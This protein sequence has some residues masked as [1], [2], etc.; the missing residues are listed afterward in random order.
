M[1]SRFLKAKKRH[2]AV[3]RVNQSKDGDV[4][5]YMYSVGVCICIVLVNIYIILFSRWQE[6]EPI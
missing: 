4:Y 3:R 2:V 5:M 1:F 6:L